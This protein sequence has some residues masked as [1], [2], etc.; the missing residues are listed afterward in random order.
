MAGIICVETANA[1]ANALRLA[2][3]GS[4]KL[5]ASI[6]LDSVGH[7]ISP[8]GPNSAA[9]RQSRCFPDD[10]ALPQDEVLH[11]VREPLVFIRSRHELRLPSHIGAG[12]SHRDADPALLEHEYV[13]RHV[14]NRGDQFWLNGPRLG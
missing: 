7:N 10:F 3:G 4:H 1:A 14:A 12:V 8:G 11:G 9:R 2:A 6:R 5:W 13:V